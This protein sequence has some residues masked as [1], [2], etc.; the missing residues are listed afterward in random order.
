MSENTIRYTNKMNLYYI[1]CNYNSRNIYNA[2]DMFGKCLVEQLVHTE[3]K[4]CYTIQEGSND[5]NNVFQIIGSIVRDSHKDMVIM[6]TGILAKN[7][8]IKAFKECYIQLWIFTDI[9][10]NIW[11]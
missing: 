6:G 8:I 1:I 2:G 4:H 7:D 3:I 5:L 9:G 10:W 11:L